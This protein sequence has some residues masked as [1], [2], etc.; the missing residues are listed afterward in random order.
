MEQYEKA[1]DEALRDEVFAEELMAGKAYTEEE[2]NELMTILAEEIS[3]YDT[4]NQGEIDILH[5]AED[6]G[7]LPA[8][9]GEAY[10]GIERSN[11]V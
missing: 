1:L 4:G 5:E 8:S 11:Q 6:I 9:E 2:Y 10:G 7:D 3:D